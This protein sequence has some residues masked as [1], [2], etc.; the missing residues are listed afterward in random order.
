MATANLNKSEELVTNTTT[1]SKYIP[2][3]PRMRDICNIWK[4]DGRLFASHSFT[5]SNPVALLQSKVQAYYF[6]SVPGARHIFRQRL[7]NLLSS[8]Y[9]TN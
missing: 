7:L 2:K 8:V 3:R 6:L 1:A 9:F 4:K 5:N